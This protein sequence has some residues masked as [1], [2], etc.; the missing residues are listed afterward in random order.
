[1]FKDLLI[2][3][4]SFFAFLLV[5]SG[6]SVYFSPASIWF[7][8]FYGLAYPFLLIIN[9]IFIFLWFLWFSKKRFTLVSIAA[10]ILTWSSFSALFNFSM[11]NHSDSDISV[12]TWNV[13]NFD[14]YNWS[15]NKETHELMMQLLEKEK[16]DVLCLQE[17]YTETSGNFKN[18]AELKMRLG[19]KYYYFGETFSVKNGTKKW[20]LA[21]FSKFPIKDHGTIKFD[22]NLRLNAC[23]YT[24]IAYKKDSIFRVYNVHFQSLHFADEDYK[25]FSELKEEQKADVASSKKILK[26]IRN[27]FEKRAIQALKIKTEMDAFEGKK[28]ICGDFNDTPTSYTYHVLSNNMKDS[29]KEKGFGF[30]NTLVNPTPFFRI[31]FMLVD[32]SITVNSYETF[33]KE[34]SD[35][36]PVMVHLE[37]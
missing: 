5:L 23:I 4:N 20:G 18:I 25:Y 2:Y 3:I 28:L 15:H 10:I 30:G 16:P 34:Y 17:F 37:L 21:T 1:M 22:D 14:L 29:F 26:K 12:M 8:A 24:D 7:P 31:D 11:P 36:Y 19:F 9:I 32:E 27:G 35:H 33:K 6:Y 13:K